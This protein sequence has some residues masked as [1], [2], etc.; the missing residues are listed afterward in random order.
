[1]KYL[2]IQLARFG[3]LIQTKRLLLTLLA[4]PD[5]EVHLCLDRS[6]CD[7]ARLVYP[8]VHLHPVAAHGTG[9][10]GAD[11]LRAML[12]DNAQAFEELRNAGFHRVYNLNYSSMSF[13]LA[14]LFPPETVRGYLWNEGQELVGLWPRLGFRFASD[15][16]SSLNL[17]DYWANFATA[18]L[19]PELVNPPAQGRGGGVGV[20]L[21]GRESRR[22][23]PPKV[24]ATIAAHVCRLEKAEG[25]VLL[26]SA[27]EAAAGRAVLKE[28]PSAVQAK[29]RNLAGKTGW[30]ELVDVVSGLDRVLTPDTGTMHLAAHLGVPVTAFFLSSAWCHETGPYGLGHRVLQAAEHCT[31]CLESAPCTRGVKCLRGF[32]QP[33]L[34]RYLSTDR[35]EHLPEGLEDLKTGFDDLGLCFEARQADRRGQEAGAK[36]RARLRAFLCRHLGHQV[37]APDRELADRLYRESDWMLPPRG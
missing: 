36:A 34:L 25:M 24:L 18:P 22:S 30:R 3:D 32:T 10:S 26:G 16:R 27:A 35:C 9:L 23:L 33:S 1:M 21:A 28:L 8:D 19:A 4:R 5:A 17:V 6:L 2:V 11:A 31:P 29:T 37:T 14:A 7:M 13:R 12:V 20:V 15:R